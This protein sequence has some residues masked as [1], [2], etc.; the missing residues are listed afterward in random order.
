MMRTMRNIV[1]DTLVAIVATITGAIVYIVVMAIMLL[2]CA[3]YKLRG[4]EL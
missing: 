2:A 4:K 1:T 3:Y